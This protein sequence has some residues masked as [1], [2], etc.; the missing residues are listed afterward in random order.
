MSDVKLIFVLMQNYKPCLNKFGSLLE[1]AKHQLT[2]YQPYP[3]RYYFLASFIFA[4]DSE[5]SI[6]EVTIYTSAAVWIQRRNNNLSVDEETALAK[7]FKNFVRDGLE[8]LILIDLIKAYG[9]KPFFTELRKYLIEQF[10]I[11]LGSL[12]QSKLKLCAPVYI[13]AE[14]L[15]CKR[16]NFLLPQHLKSVLLNVDR[17]YTKDSHVL[18][19]NEYQ[20]VF[21]ETEKLFAMEK[22]DT[23]IV[24]FAA[25]LER[26]M[27]FLS[28]FSHK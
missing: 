27:F 24:H 23:E 8:S 11:S 18:S 14:L 7:D 19:Q 17:W 4:F 2:M 26:L 13:L 25:T 16:A 15:Y 3:P 22:L 10:T 20:E 1:K 9:E 6:T 5:E 28:L 21:I 12:Y